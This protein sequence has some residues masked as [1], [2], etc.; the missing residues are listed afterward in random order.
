MRITAAILLSCLLIKASSQQTHSIPEFKNLNPKDQYPTNT[1]FATYAS[2]FDILISLKGYSAWGP[3]HSIKILAYHKCGWY[4]IEVNTDERSLDPYTVCYLTAKIN[5]TVGQAIWETL[6]HNHFFEMKDGRE[7]ESVCFSKPDT[8]KTDKG[9]IQLVEI[10]TVSSDGPEYEFE[11][12]TKTSYK[13]LYFY[14]PQN[15]VDACPQP[16]RRWI[17]NCITVFEKYLGR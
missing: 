6:K 14:S 13:K 10:S 17:L 7:I 12:L 16:E 2:S 1:L 15:L 11:I 4:K 5:D 8:V 9:K 3:D